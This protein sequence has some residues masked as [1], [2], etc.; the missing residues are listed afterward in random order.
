MPKK[1][2]KSAKKIK[3]TPFKEKMS[4]LKRKRK[5]KEKRTKINFRSI[6]ARVSILCRNI[7]NSFFNSEREKYLTNELK[8]LW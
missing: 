8:K 6:K 1:R 7:S 4:Q 5:E 2:A 3:S